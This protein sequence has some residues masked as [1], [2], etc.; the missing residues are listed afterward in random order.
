MSQTL[1]NSYLHTL[2]HLRNIVFFHSQTVTF[3]EKHFFFWILGDAFF[4]TPGISWNL[5]DSQFSWESKMEPS[6]AISTLPSTLE[7][8]NGW[9]SDK[10]F[11]H[12]SPNSLMTKVT[13]KNVTITHIIRTNVTKKN[14]ALDIPNNKYKIHS[15]NTPSGSDKSFYTALQTV[16]WQMLL[17]HMGHRDKDGKKVDKM[18]LFFLKV[19]SWYGQIKAKIDIILSSSI[20]S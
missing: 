12:H 10:S 2:I 16:S 18:S 6:V 5:A 14:A 11:L 7:V 8:W 15:P 20:L 9:C 17:G 13:N 3:G 19:R 1:W 4:G